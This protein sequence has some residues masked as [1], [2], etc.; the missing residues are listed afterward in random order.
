MSQFSADPYADIRSEVAKLCQQFPGEYWRKLERD[1]ALRTL[2]LVL[3]RS[4][5]QKVI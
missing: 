3:S 1:M 2:E 5:D 4:N